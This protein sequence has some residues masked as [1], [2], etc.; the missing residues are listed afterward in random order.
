MGAGKTLHSSGEKPGG[1][2]KKRS[3]KQSNGIDRGTR[4]G[5]NHHRQRDPEN[6]RRHGRPFSSGRAHGAGRETHERN[7]G[8]SGKD[9]SPPAGIQFPR[10]RVPEKRGKALGLRRTDRG[11]SLHDRHGADAPFDKSDSSVSDARPGGRRQP[12]AFRGTRQR[13][14]GH[15]FLGSRFRGETDRNIQTGGGEQDHR[16]RPPDQQRRFPSAALQRP[17]RSSKRLLFHPEGRSRGGAEYHSGTGLRTNSETLRV[18]SRRRFAGADPDASRS[19]RRLKPE[20]ISPGTAQSRRGTSGPGR[21]RLQ[22]G[23][24]GDADSKQL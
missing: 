8:T 17:V 3:R 23:R 12:A 19:R 6:L 24:Q 1:G 22:G 20:Q 15:H 13:V 11:R 2:H 5:K 16:E 18:R 10:R 14:E 4:H 7:D 9:A 21:T